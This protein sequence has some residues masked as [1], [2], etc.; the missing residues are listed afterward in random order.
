MKKIFL[1]CSIM[2]FCGVHAAEQ[3]IK[4]PFK[5]DPPISIDGDIADWRDVKCGVIALDG[6]KDLLK[7]GNIK[8]PPEKQDFSGKLYFCWKPQGLFVAAEVLDDKFIQTASG[9]KC[10]QG[11]HVEL[12]IDPSSN[13]AMNI[14]RTSSGDFRA[15]PSIMPRGKLFLDRS[16]L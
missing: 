12:F 10:Y 13:S 11:D 15:K 3:L 4:I 6:K 1:L 14:A 5:Q 7:Y 9:R 2:L 8:N 16:R